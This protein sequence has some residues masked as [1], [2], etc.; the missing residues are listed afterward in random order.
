METEIV[1]TSKR[2]ILELSE[3]TYVYIPMTKE[4]S[5]RFAPNIVNP[6]WRIR[7]YKES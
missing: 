1:G 3:F 4:E 5:D 7:I 6:C 2:Q